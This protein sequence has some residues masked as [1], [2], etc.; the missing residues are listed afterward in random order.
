MVLNRRPQNSPQKRDGRMLNVSRSIQ[1]YVGDYMIW[2]RSTPIWRKN[3]LEMVRDLPPTSRE[4]AVRRLFKV[5][6]VT[7]VQYIYK[8]PCLLRDS[9]PDPT[10]QQSVPLYLMSLFFICCF[11][12]FVLDAPLQLNSNYYELF[13]LIMPKV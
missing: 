13:L 1:Y 7:M 3:T 9:N 2:F 6:P 10:V 12:K 4:V 5:P 8:H 11:A